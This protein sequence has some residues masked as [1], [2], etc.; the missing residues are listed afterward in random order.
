MDTDPLQANDFLGLGLEENLFSQADSDFIQ[1]ALRELNRLWDIADH[2]VSLSDLE[3]I[4][5]EFD[6]DQTSDFLIELIKNDQQRR[7]QADEPFDLHFYFDHFPE[8]EKNHDRVISLA[9]SEFCVLEYQGERVD[10]D[11]FCEKYEV[12]GDSIRR[13]LAIH[14]LLSIPS[15]ELLG[16]KAVRHFPKPGD[17]IDHFK[18]EREIGRGGTARVFLANDLSLGQRQVVLKVSGDISTEPEIL[19]RLEHDNIVPVL[20][21]HDADDGLRLICMPYLG[22]VTLEHFFN[23]LYKGKHNLPRDAKEFWAT[24]C[25]LNARGPEPKV[26]ASPEN[27]CW[28]DFPKTGLFTDAVAWIGWKLASALAHAHQQNIFHRDIKPA[29]SLMSRKSGPQLLDFNMARDPNVVNQI[30][31]KIRGGTLPYMAPEQLAAFIDPRL[32]TEI[33]GR[34]DIYSLGL[35][36]KEFITGKRVCVPLGGNATMLEQVR[37][38]LRQRESKWV[39]LKS[40]NSQVTSALDAVLSKSLEFR[41]SDR[42]QDA[43]Q[44]AT[45]LKCILDRKPLKTAWNPS[46]RERSLMA[47]RPLRKWALM[48]GLVGLS[49]QFMANW[50]TESKL[51][52]PN[53]SAGIIRDLKRGEYKSAFRA[54]QRSEAPETNSTARD[55]IRMISWNESSPGDVNAEELLK[56]LVTRPDL[57]SSCRIVKDAIGKNRHLDFILIYREYCRLAQLQQKG[58]AQPLEW[59]DLERQF[60]QFNQ[61]WPNDIRPYGF[62]IYLA[63]MRADYQTVYEQSLQG[64]KVLDSQ[65]GRDVGT[66]RS[67][68]IQHKIKSRFQLAAEAQKN[69]RPQFA[70]EL[71]QACLDDIRSFKVKDS[72][73][74]INPESLFPMMELEILSEIGIGDIKTDQLKYDEAL[75][76]YKSVQA[77]LKRDLE[78]F[79]KN[80]LYEKFNSNLE[81]RI[82]RIGGLE[83]ASGLINPNSN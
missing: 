24:Y 46:R 69:D 26:P 73:G 59:Q 77:M 2:S 15:N 60:Y 75:E 57:D 68:L 64:L 55:L 47:V 42:Y 65:P 39:S 54:L 34:A 41:P 53:V 3:R 9:Y 45:D 50:L 78:L 80:G 28:I 13:Q 29:N 5:M 66:I 72:R 70:M 21:V 37:A 16:H 12:W 35:V 20:S 71:Y 17:Q 19:A 30:E 1:L 4:W 81:L 23:K 14:Q 67:D 25:E 74:Q 40:T 11:H 8:L 38:L 48:L 44:L 49:Y 32:W 58:I 33:S 31:D 52:I 6:P 27:A 36:L 61:N 43:F 62:L 22:S 63:S 18:L 56:N 7:I 83:K 82:Q 51:S 10:V 79:V 76:K